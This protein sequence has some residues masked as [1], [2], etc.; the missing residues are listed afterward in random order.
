MKSS[1]KYDFIKFSLCPKSKCHYFCHLL[2]YK[3][4]IDGLLRVPPLEDGLELR[5]FVSKLCAFLSLKRQRANLLS[6]HVERSQ[7]KAQC[8]AVGSPQ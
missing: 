6:S 4:R 5:S 3:E 2:R 1:H 8:Q 7:V